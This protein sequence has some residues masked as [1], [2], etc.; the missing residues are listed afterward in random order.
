MRDHPVR[1]TAVRREPGWKKRQVSVFHTGRSTGDR[2]QVFGRMKALAS[3]AGMA[4]PTMPHHRR[5]TPTPDS[6][7]TFGRALVTS[8]LFEARILQTSPTED[9]HH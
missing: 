7:L 9:A 6:D 5:G 4:Y 1:Y 3:R 2:V 8:R